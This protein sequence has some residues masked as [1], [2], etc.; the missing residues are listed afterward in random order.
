MRVKPADSA[1]LAGGPAPTGVG[2]G[3]LPPEF[4][5]RSRSR[6]F[7]TQGRRVAAST[8]S[9]AVVL[10]GLAALFFA[11]PGS[12][13][14]REG[15]F[16]L[17]DMWQALTGDPSRGYFSVGKGILLN[18]EMFLIAEVLILVLALGIALVRMSRS[19]VLFPF[20]L[21]AVCYVD[22]FRGVP[23][24]LVVYAI[25]FGVPTLELGFVSNQSAFVYG[26]CALVLAYSAYVSEVYRA[27][28]HAVPL[29][30]VAAARS[31][32]L[33]PSTAFRHVVLPQAVRNVVPALLNDFI[34]LQKDTALVAILGT[35][36]E[37]LRA[38]ETYSSA[39]FN[40][41]GITVAALLFLVL[42]IPLARFTDH[43]IARDRSRRLAGAMP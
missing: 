28:I 33:R 14:V 1:Y 29:S 34:G 38:G 41:S 20:R 31:L 12:R 42:T 37:A 30:Q 4:F 7:A 39:V 5:R 15:F 32:G 24:L 21:L 16:N 3:G 36:I 8:I 13:K 2:A 9:T 11:A 23:L 6:L 40:D 43:V 19:P 22:F 10:G 27:G 25:G 26:T 17:H 18:V 35:V